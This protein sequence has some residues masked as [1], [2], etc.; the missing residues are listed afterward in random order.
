LAQEQRLRC[1][2]PEVWKEFGALSKQL[3]ANRKCL[4]M[5]RK[6]SYLQE[7]LPIAPAAKE[8]RIQHI[9]NGAYHR[10]FSE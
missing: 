4:R 5:C 9:A 3:N 8:P 2:T 10:L 6:A 1:K 7:L